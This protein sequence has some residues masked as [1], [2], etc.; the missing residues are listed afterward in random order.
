MIQMH[1]IAGRPLPLVICDKCG[2]ELDDYAEARVLWDA[3]AVP[4]LCYHVHPGPCQKLITQA[5]GAAGG[6]AQVDDL[7]THLARLAHQAP[8]R[9]SPRP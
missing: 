1:L 3:Q 7:G 4:A 6:E 9:L 5:I 2:R 8:R